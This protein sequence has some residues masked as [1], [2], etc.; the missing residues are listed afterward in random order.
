[1]LHGRLLVLV[2]LLTY[3]LEQCYAF[4]GVTAVGTRYQLPELAS[5]LEK[6]EVLE[7]ILKEV[8]FSAYNAMTNKFE[9]A[10]EISGFSIKLLELVD[11][12]RATQL[13]VDSHFEKPFEES[14]GDSM[15]SKIIK[16]ISQWANNYLRNDLYRQVLD[17]FVTRAHRRL[18]YPTVSLSRESAI[19]AAYDTK[20]PKKIVGVI[21]VYPTKEAYICNLSVASEVRR[22]GLARVMCALTEDLVKSHWGTYTITLHVE[23]PNIRARNLYES[24]DYQQTSVKKASLY[25]YESFIGVKRE[26]INYA[27]TLER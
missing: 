18:K 20:N 24:L 4:N 1:M 15:K 9:H 19:I 21:E 2:Y 17:G 6:S 12:R 14:D 23:R 27:K 11:L 13:V 22:R 25:G 8:P 7:P 5:V 26:L 3:I 10:S 16:P